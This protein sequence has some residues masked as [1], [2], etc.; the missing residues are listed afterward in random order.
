MTEDPTGVKQTPGESPSSGSGGGSPQSD[1]SS[2]SPGENIEFKEEDAQE[3]EGKKMVPLDV[4]TA[5][6]KRWQDKV[7]E[8]ENKPKEPPPQEPPPTE[9]PPVPEFDWEAFFGK[10]AEGDGTPQQPTQ[11]PQQPQ[12]PGDINQWIEDEWE[13]GNK[14]GAL[15]GIYHVMRSH[16]RGLTNEARAFVPDYDN[17]PVN[18]VSDQDLQRAMGNPEAVRALIAK[19][20]FGKPAQASS[21]PNNP[22]PSDTPTNSGFEKREQ[23]IRAEERRKFMEELAQG[24]GMTGEAGS[25]GGTSTEETFELDDEGKAYLAKRGIKDPEKIKSFIKRYRMEQERKTAIV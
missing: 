16:E 21:Q 14:A 22:Q 18:R 11:T 8:L 1:P 13:K 17:L 25:G 5:E 4:L 24:T 3:V 20:R 10:P 2:P 7:A 19:L 23:E 15:A 12:A 9:E 6:R